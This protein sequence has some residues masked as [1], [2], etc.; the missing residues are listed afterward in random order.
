MTTKTKT[1]K[2]SNKLTNKKP[3]QRKLKAGNVLVTG[4]LASTL[5]VTRRKGRG[6]ETITMTVNELVEKHVWWSLI[7]DK[8]NENQ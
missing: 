2:T 6:F 3:D 5:E 4:P 1:K 8:E 7:F